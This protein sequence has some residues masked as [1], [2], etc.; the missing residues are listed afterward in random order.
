MVIIL[1]NIGFFVMAA[2]ALWR[3]RMNQ[4]GKMDRKNIGS[5]LKVLAFLLI[6]MGTTWIVGVLVMEV[7]ALLPLA[8]IFTIMVAFQGVSIFLSVVAFQKSVRDEYIKWWKKRVKTSDLLSKYYTK[9]LG[10]STLKV[11]YVAR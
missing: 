4:K 1:T 6:I 2:V 9:S 5:W 10:V 7:D 3:Q 11:C 8:Y